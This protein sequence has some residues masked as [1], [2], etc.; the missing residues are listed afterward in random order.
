MIKTQRLLSY[1]IVMEFKLV[2][3][4]IPEGCNLILAQS[5]FIKTVEDVYDALSSSTAVIKFGL[6]F[7][8]SSGERLVRHEGNDEE[9]RKVASKNAFR[10]GCGHSLVILLKDAYPINVLTQLKMV[11]EICKIYAA[12]ANPLQVIVV[13]TSQGKGIMGVI[14]GYKPAGIEGEDGIKWRKDFLRKIGYKT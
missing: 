14:D 9:L 8:E 4:T 3:L 12:T 7:C 11:P 1:L 13:E 2:E 10:L 6:G 5:H